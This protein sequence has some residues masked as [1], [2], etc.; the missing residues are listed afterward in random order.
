MSSPAEPIPVAMAVPVP[1]S[2]S[3]AAASAPPPLAPT[4][5]HQQASTVDDYFLPLSLAQCIRRTV[6]D[7]YLGHLDTF[8]TLTVLVSLPAIVGYQWMRAG[9]WGSSWL[10]N[11]WI[12]PLTRLLAD[13]AAVTATAH[14]YLRQGQPIPWKVPLQ[15]ALSNRLWSRWL[16][17]ILRS[18]R[19]VGFLLVPTGIFTFVSPLLLLQQASLV[20]SLVSSWR[21]VWFHSIGTLITTGIVTFAVTPMLSWLLRRLVGNL[22]MVNSNDD[23]LEEDTAELVEDDSLDNFWSQRRQVQEVMVLPLISCLWTVLFLNICIRRRNNP[24][25]R[26]KLA[27]TM[28]VQL[29]PSLSASVY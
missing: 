18:Q 23:H 14:I 29:P 10:F 26:T 4:H 3:R 24:L 21:L 11:Y 7:V 15:S 12:L 20:G 28:G 1:S 17:Q 27:R 2:S 25:T 8:L 19:F 22:V 6:V 5:S 9:Y 16:L 13:G